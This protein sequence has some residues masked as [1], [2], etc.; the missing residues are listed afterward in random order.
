ML[1]SPKLAILQSLDAM[2]K[3]QMEEVLHYIKGILNQPEK[4][5]D[6]KAFKKEAMKEIRKALRQENSNRKMRLAV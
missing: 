5:S 1:Q 3:V 6:Y 2:D 4:N